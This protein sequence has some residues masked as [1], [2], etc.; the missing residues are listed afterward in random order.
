MTYFEILKFIFRLDVFYEVFYQGTFFR[1]K[2]LFWV[3]QQN[4]APIFF[5]IFSAMTI[6]DWRA[7]IDALNGELITLLNKRASFAHEI[8]K[9]KKQ[10]GLPVLDEG[11]E[12]R[13]L[14]AVGELAQKSG[15]P[16]TEESVKRIFQVIMEETRKV[17]D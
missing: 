17:E 2:W 6:E 16:L 10:A 8:G 7:R 5:S 3:V 14:D 15:G 4:H 13:V 12:A 11:R 9:V 1:V